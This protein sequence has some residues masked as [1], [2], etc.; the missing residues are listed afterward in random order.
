[1][2]TM[3]EGIAFLHARPEALEKNKCF[4][5]GAS[6]GTD[7]RVPALLD[8]GAGT[9]PRLVLGEQPPHLARC[10]LGR[11]ED[12]ATGVIAPTAPT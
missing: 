8:R 9:A 10:R 2:L 12:H 6:R 11:D 7:L 1:M 5:T 3:E 4:H